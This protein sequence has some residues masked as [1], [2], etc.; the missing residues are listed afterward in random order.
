M[1][2][3]AA[4][5]NNVEL[6]LETW[7]T[8]PSVELIIQEDLEK[9]LGVQINHH[10]YGLRKILK[11]LLLLRWGKINPYKGKRYDLVFDI[12]EGDSFADIYGFQRFIKFSANKYFAISSKVPLIIAPQTI[13]PFNNYISS[14]IATYLLKQAQAVYTRDHKSSDYLKKMK[15][16]HHEASDV[17]FLLP[18]D[19]KNKIDNSVGINVSGLLW[20]GGYTKRN[21]FNLSVDYQKLIVDLINGF[22]RREQKVYLVAHVISDTD[23]VEDDYRTA[24]KIKAEYF[25]ENDLVMVAPK[26]T[27][28][29]EAKSFISSMM[30]FLGS[31]MHATIG[32]ISAGVPTIPLAYSRKFSGVFGTISYPHTYDL[33]GPAIEN[34]I[35]NSIF[36]KFDNDILQ[37]AQDAKQSSC[38]AKRQLEEYESFLLENLR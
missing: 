3:N 19:Q 5:K 13:G 2:A 26:F 29:I 27:S 35:L 38:N 10:N 30:F 32:A 7:G 34:E 17:A 20:H 4:K 21:Q 36:S 24:E 33:Y 28:P 9:R 1:L 8:P 14:I 37:I 12:G 15:V 23:D 16:I 11:D 18:Y 22:I 25:S 31:R 6:H